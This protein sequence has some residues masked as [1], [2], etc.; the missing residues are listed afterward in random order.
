[1]KKTPTNRYLRK[2]VVGRLRKLGINSMEA[3]V[4]FAKP[5]GNL[6]GFANLLGLPG[7]DFLLIIRAASRIIDVPKRSE[8]E[9]P[10]G[11]TEPKKGRRWVFRDECEGQPFSKINLT[12]AR[13]STQA[14]CEGLGLRPPSK[15]YG[16]LVDEYHRGYK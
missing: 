5:G 1:M 12:M 14:A 3:L 13:I 16:Q 7:K 2:D 10:L 8:R 4:S 9:Y 11:A 6:E 15:S